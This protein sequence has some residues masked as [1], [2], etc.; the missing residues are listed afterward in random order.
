MRDADVLLH[1]ASDPR[2]ANLLS[3]ACNVTEASALLSSAVASIRSHNLLRESVASGVKGKQAVDAGRAANDA[4][5]AKVFG[6]VSSAA[7][8]SRWAGL[9]LL[10]VTVQECSRQRLLECYN[11]W[12]MKVLPFLKQ[13][14]DPVFV[15]AAA[16]AS[17]TDLIVRLGGLTEVVG[18][19]RDCANFISKFI[20]PLL[21]LIGDKNSNVLLNEAMD[22]LIAVLKNFP[23]CLRQQFIN[24][25]VSLVARFTDVNCHSSVGQKCAKALA[26]LPK[27]QGDAASWSSLMRR[28]LIA[29]NADLD[30]AFRG[31]EDASVAEGAT[32]A[33][34][35]Q[36]QGPPRSLGEDPQKPLGDQSLP[37]STGIQ[38]GKNLWSQLLPR[39]SY[40]LHCCNY[41]LISPYPTPVPAPV[42]PLLSL[43]MRI[44]GVDGSRSSSSL[45]SSV[46]SSQHVSVCSELPALHLSALELLSATLRGVRGQLLPRGA[47][48]ARLL[49]DHFRRTGGRYPNLR[50]NLYAI[51]RH[52]FIAMGAGMTSALAPAVVGSALLDLKGSSSR[53]HLPPSNVA[54]TSG[55]SSGS[56]GTNSKKR[57]EAGGLPGDHS[58]NDLAEVANVEGEG[59]APLAVQV[60]A[61]QALEALLNTGGALLP[62]R[63]RAEVDA[64]LAGVA[65]GVAADTTSFNI[66]CDKDSSHSRK[67]TSVDMQVAAYQALLAS[68]L[69]PCG[70]RPPY[71]A[72]G[73]ALFRNGRKEVGTEVATVCARALMALEPL[74]HPRCLPSVNAFTEMAGG[75]GMNGTPSYLQK[76]NKSGHPSSMISGGNDFG[77]FGG[78]SMKFGHMSMDPWAEVDT[79]L[80]YGDDTGDD[81]VI[82]HPERS[83][84]LLNGVANGSPGSLAAE[85]VSS[86]NGINNGSLGAADRVTSA[87]SYEVRLTTP[88]KPSKN[89][90][91]EDPMQIETETAVPVNNT[92]ARDSNETGHAASESRPE[93]S[94]SK[95]KLCAQTPSAT[96]IAEPTSQG[97]ELQNSQ[98]PVPENELVTTSI[99][100]ATS[101][102]VNTSTL[103]S[104]SQSNHASSSVIETKTV[105]VEVTTSTVS[106]A[107]DILTFPKAAHQVGSDSDSDGPLP[108]IVDGDPDPESD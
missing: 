5:V 93:D 40:L 83:D 54:K 42:G 13:Q 66:S 102:A 97:G 82:S 6:L 72:Q 75:H 27:A 101:T 58:I 47:A 63:W 29:I 86:A 60:A 28:I 1:L 37:S 94:L 2:L 67:S 96:N 61:L 48:L 103:I 74:I 45:G 38:P 59:R 9:C 85:K 39:I 100:I 12:F 11:S 65:I 16:C 56:Q 55:V 79:W 80:G 105:S 87:H 68:L 90:L 98:S 22:L 10:G 91:V 30:F 3:D 41:L 23:N 8:E 14:T 7:A 107:E 81:N 78:S 108:D 36:G 62:E 106:A 71:L 51:S 31:M 53:E 4:W 57:K 26:F 34:L 21:Q 92:L 69:A 95:Q 49:T 73:L 89:E 64:A 88:S 24:V 17:L 104:T 70:H 99:D 46:F 35:P 44:L 32:R 84:A 43:I 33:L 50:I 52:L 18:V 25:E 77:R 20:Q 15:R 76:S 19:R